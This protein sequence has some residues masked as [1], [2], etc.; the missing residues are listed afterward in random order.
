MLVIH[1]LLSGLMAISTG[2]M[3]KAA[4]LHAS[5][6]IYPTNAYVVM[7]LPQETMYHAMPL[8]ESSQDTS[9]RLPAASTAP[10]SLSL[11]S[12]SQKKNDLSKDTSVHWINKIH[13]PMGEI[14][15]ADSIVLYDPG[16]PGEGTGDEPAP[17]FRHAELALGT[18]D[19]RT[20]KDSG[21]VS[22]GKGGTLVLKFTDNVLMNGPGPDLCIFEGN[23]NPEDLF[24]WISQ[25]G[26]IFIPVGKVT[27]EN[28]TIDI[29]DYAELGAT[30]AYVKLRDD[31][32]Q[33]EKNT[34][35][36]GADIDAVGAIGS[37][38]RIRIPAD[39]LFERG[40][41]TFT[42][43]AESLLSG[44]AKKIRLLDRARVFIETHTD[45]R[46]FDDFNLLISQSQAGS[47]RN[48]FLDKEDLTDVEFTVLGWGKSKPIS[49]N[50][51]EDGRKKNRRVEILIEPI[52][53]NRNPK[54]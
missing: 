46:G 16:A 8:E 2:G 35:A 9:N 6:G 4:P 11:S 39:Q 28:F 38:V 48:Y 3:K 36:L 33:G 25:D 45:G 43:D 41:A 21:Y 54:E 51:T 22:L 24:V 52:T 49:S 30:Y 26:T 47:I 44:I 42:A 17:E 1:F 12:Q 27:A 18:P 34:P 14:S 23:S 37:A 15:F 13:F 7:L 53:Q 5:A 10:D 40:T 29:R 19:C 50:D 32:D 20:D 31:P